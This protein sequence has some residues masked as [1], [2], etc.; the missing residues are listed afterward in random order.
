MNRA[1]IRRDA[2]LVWETMNDNRQW[3]YRELKEATQLT[4]NELNAAIGWL[5]HENII[6]FDCSEC[7][8]DYFSLGCNF[9]I[10]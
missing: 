4:D 3:S 10:G 5:A 9:Y 8:K 6:Y 1:T 7:E 2:M